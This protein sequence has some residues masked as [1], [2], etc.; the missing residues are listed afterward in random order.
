MTSSCFSWVWHQKKVLLVIISSGVCSALCHPVEAVHLSQAWSCLRPSS[1]ALSVRPLAVV[2]DQS[3]LMTTR[4][5]LC[6]PMPCAVPTARQ[7]EYDLT[8]NLVSTSGKKHMHP[9]IQP[10]E[11]T[12]PSI[13]FVHPRANMVS[14]QSPTTTPGTPKIHMA[15]RF[16]SLLCPHMPALILVALYAAD[17]LEPSRNHPHLTGCPSTR[18]H[19]TS[20]RRIGTGT[21]GDISQVSC[22]RSADGYGKALDPHP[23]SLKTS[24]PLP[25]GP[26]VSPVVAWA[27][28]LR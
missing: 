1:V 6:C 14:S 8:L 4:K 27:S 18:S 11:H 7:I 9:Y 25:H 2:L 12:H 16:G 3:S 13:N 21:P 26:V 20:D 23:G 15:N 17:A 28:S 5:P 19:T 24:T 10:H 22:S